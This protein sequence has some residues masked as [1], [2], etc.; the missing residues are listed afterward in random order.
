MEDLNCY[1]IL[2]V[3]RNATPVDIKKAYRK[4]AAQYHPDKLGSVGPRLRKMASDE[5]SRLNMAR[6]ILLDP[7]KRMEHDRK[8]QQKGGNG[9]GV[10]KQ[11][12]QRYNFKCPHCSDVVTAVPIDRPYV[13]SCP[14][15]MGRMTIPRA[16]SNNTAGSPDRVM[17]YKEAVRRALLDGIITRD[18]MSMLEGLRSVLSITDRQH[19]D[20]IMEIKRSL[21]V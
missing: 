7:N 15:C 4:L 5:M 14:K 1:R 3:D 13:I 19:E 6:D 18:E 20:T 16:N 2:E 10:R 21:R 8:L 12:Q 11:N 17:V 9:S